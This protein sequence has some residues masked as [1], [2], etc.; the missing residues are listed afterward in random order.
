MAEEILL[1]TVAE[2][3]SNGAE[4]NSKIAEFDAV[5]REKGAS[6]DDDDNDDDSDRR[7]TIE[8]SDNDD[9]IVATGDQDKIFGKKGKDEIRGNRG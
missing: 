8:G 2:T 1:G 4:D 5:P 7:R 9:L 3:P 6:G